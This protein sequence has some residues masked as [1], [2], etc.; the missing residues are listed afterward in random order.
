MNTILFPVSTPSYFETSILVLLSIHLYF[1]SEA[2]L[3]CLMSPPGWV[4]HVYFPTELFLL[5]LVALFP[6]SS[7]LSCCC[8]MCFQSAHQPHT[9][10]WLFVK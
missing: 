4:K 3:K 8:E 1:V 5:I 7:S 6:K 9:Q 2:N 10:L